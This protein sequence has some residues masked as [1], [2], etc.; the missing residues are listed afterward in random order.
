M[1]KWLGDIAEDASISFTWSTNDVDGASITRATDGEVRVYKDGGVGQSTAGVTDT[2][3]FDGLTGVHLCVIDTSA[4]AFYATG[5]DYSVVLQCAVIDGQ[6]VNAVL[7][8]FSIE[9]RFAEVDL[10]HILGHLLTQTGTQVAD[11]FEHFF[12]VA[13]PTGTVDSLPSA[14]PGATGGLPVRGGAIPDAAADAAGGLPI[15]DAGGLDLDNLEVDATKISGSSTAADVLAAKNFSAHSD[16]VVVVADSTTDT[17][18][19]ANLRTAY[20]A[21]KALTP[22]GNALAT[23]N[24][25]K[26]LVPDGRYDFGTGDVS[27]HG[28]EVDG[29]FVD[30]FSLSGNRDHVVFTSQ[31][32][33][34]SRG[35]LEQTADDMR[36]SGIT[37]DIAAASQA[38]AEA[39]RPAAYFPA[40][41]L[42]NAKIDNCKFTTQNGTNAYAMRRTVEYSGEHTDCKCVGD[43]GF[44]GEGTLSGTCT[45]CKC[46]GL[47]GF[48][49]NGTLSGDCTDCVHTGNGGFGGNTGTASG[50]CVNCEHI[51]TYGFGG[52]FGTASGTFINCKGVGSDNFGGGNGLGVASGLFRN[53]INIGHDSFGGAG[54]LASGTFVDCVNMGNNGFG[55]SSGAV[56]GLTGKLIRC[57]AFG[58]SSNIRCEGAII[59]DCFLG[60]TM[61]DQDVLVLEDDDTVVTNSTILVVEGGTGIPIDDDGNARTVCA[62]GN[63]FNNLDASATGLGTLVTNKGVGEDVATLGHSDSALANLKAWHDGTRPVLYVSKSGDDANDGSGWGKAKLTI[64]AAV[65]AASNGDEIKIGPGTFNENVSLE[66]L[67]GLRLQLNETIIT[68]SSGQPAPVLVM[69]ENSLLYGIGSIIGTTGIGKMNG[70]MLAKGAKII[71]VTIIATRNAI[72]S[73]GRDNWVIDRCILQGCEYGIVNAGENYRYRISNSFVSTDG[74]WSTCSS[75]AIQNL[76]GQGI[77]VD[78]VVRGH[79]A[80]GGDADHQVFGLANCRGLVVIN[81]NITAVQG[82]GGSHATAVHFSE[83]EGCCTLVNCKVEANASSEAYDLVQDNAG[84]L[85]VS[86]TQYDPVKTS[87]TITDLDERAVANILNDPVPGSPTVHS[88]YQRFKAL[89]ELIE[90][91][92]DGDLAKVLEDTNELQTNQGSWITATGFATETKQDTAKTVLD[93]VAIDVAGLDGEPMR[94][95]DGANQTVPDAAGIVATALGVLQ[96][97]GDDTWAASGVGKTGYKLAADGLDSIAATEPTAKPTN[98]REWLMWLVQRFRRAKLDRTAGTLTVEKEDGTVVTQQDVSDD[99]VA[100]QLGKPS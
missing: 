15:S 77:I 86:G 63:R 51:G 89:D 13:T 8:E 7:A 52:A 65:S 97:H 31:I 72:V 56:G 66:G 59:E 70:V 68:A 34:A 61:N 29:E 74:S 24:R 12:D 44:G 20:T 35:T 14:V 75:G 78:S 32:A 88:P 62:S 100:Q 48:G 94:G 23:N 42:S 50:T 49:G 36:I 33:T 27:N 95:T 39:T 53:C 96:T 30:L 87:G 11:G 22:G 57:V 82:N 69:G 73:I 6:T 60:T 37:M 91:G 26:V 19:A 16:G 21:A 41:A 46:V 80:S 58:N 38:G 43:Y 67:T 17:G 85:S 64:G 28:L 1:N 90:A 45:N 84:V 83:T 99:G 5:S 2:E 40:T 81:T 3:D 79:I 98:F 93:A 4:D 76:D 92:G 47:L 55:G 18:R 25:G 71:G 9:N 54:A 10:T